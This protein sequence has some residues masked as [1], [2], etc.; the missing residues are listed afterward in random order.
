MSQSRCPKCGYLFWKR[1][2]FP[3][4][5]ANLCGQKWPLGKPKKR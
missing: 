5:C 2:D 4:R 1:V 3:R